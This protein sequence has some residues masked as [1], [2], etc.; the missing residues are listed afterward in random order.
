MMCGFYPPDAHIVTGACLAPPLPDAAVMVIPKEPIGCARAT[1]FVPQLH[2][3]SAWDTLLD[4]QI[5]GHADGGSVDGGT[6]GAPSDGGT[7]QEGGGG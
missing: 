1:A 7:V 2:P 4:E 5:A 3:L 6:D